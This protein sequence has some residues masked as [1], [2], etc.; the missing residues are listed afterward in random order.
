MIPRKALWLALGWI[1]A[2]G[3]QLT[4]ACAQGTAFTYQG[5]LTDGNGPA[6][7]V[8]DFRF[9]L[10]SDTLANTYVGSVFGSDQR[11]GPRYRQ[12]R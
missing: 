8:Y 12:L 9:R 4:T 10:A 7:G 5:H 11:H 2:F 1:I 6:T 3:G